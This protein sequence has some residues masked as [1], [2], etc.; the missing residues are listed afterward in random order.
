MALPSQGGQDGYKW[1]GTPY[2]NDFN[3]CAWAKRGWTFQEAELSRRQ[4][5]FGDKMF[6]LSTANIK[7]A[8]TAKAL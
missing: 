8:A 4:L 6:Y 7:E 1:E 5:I 3:H 2:W